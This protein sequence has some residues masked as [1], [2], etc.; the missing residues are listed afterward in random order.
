[1]RPARARCA[2]AAN[3]YWVQHFSATLAAEVSIAMFHAWHEPVSVLLTLALLTAVAGFLLWIR[4][5]EIDRLRRALGLQTARYAAVI[6]SATDAVVS[7]DQEQR[8]VVFNAAAEQLFGCSRE[9]ALG[10]SIERFVPAALRGRHAQR[11]QEFADGSQPNVGK[12]LGRDIPVLRA[13]GR[14]VMVEATVSKTE[15]PG[16]DGARQLFTAV[17]RDV[18]ARRAAASELHRVSE[19]YRIVVEQ[20]PDA[21]WLAEN[22]R[23]QL[24]N[25]VC[26]QLLG[27]GSAAELLGRPVL[28]F[29][30]EADLDGAASGPMRTELTV[31]RLDGS[32]CDVE[33]SMAAVPDHGGSAVQGVMRDIGERK[34]AEAELRQT[35]QAL[36]Q[37]QRLAKLGYVSLDRRR[38]VWTISPSVAEVL[39]LPAGRTLSYAEGPAHVHP[40]DRRA[41]FRHLEEEV[42]PGHKAY[43]HEFRIVRSSDG[44]VRWLH[45]VGEPERDADGQVVALF[46]TVQDITERKLAVLALERS[47][48]ELRRVSA[49]VTWA[50]EA[51]RR[52]VAR[53]LHDELGQRLLALKLELS[54]LEQGA[55]PA[56]L[57]GLLS[58]VDD[59]L[60]ATRR[61]AADLRPAMLDDLGLSAALEWLTEDW[62]RRTGMQM[63]VDADSVQEGLSDDAATAVYRIVQEALTNVARHAQASRVTVTLRRTGEELVVSVEDDGRGLAPGDIDKRGSAGLAGI[64]ERA[65]ILGGKARMHNAP[66]GGCRI[67][68]RLPL[69]RTQVA[70]ASVQAEE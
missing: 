25:P 9:Q 42:F 37:A 22:G 62:G 24:V 33:L 49:S 18:T 17:L 68:V 11:V 46:G 30:P 67:E 56:N 39:G 41:L 58:A 34:R 69:E 48:E 43:D 5:R 53:E 45:A 59:A 1:M 38:G 64:R 3:L 21:I 70:A 31:R 50:R 29:L 10:S 20:S 14:E 8:I 7:T 13:D 28:D 44:E 12:G 15:E 4:R 52:H 6:E 55:R 40:D 60:A 63:A 54:A 65:R 27:A 66:Q 47:R 57:R 26:V 23:L 35:Q 36:L 32:P 61:L 2:V 51:E 19:R 16:S